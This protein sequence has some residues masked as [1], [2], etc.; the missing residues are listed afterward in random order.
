M[1]DLVS[2][3]YQDFVI[4]NGQFIGKFEEMYEKFPDPWHQSLGA[5]SIPRYLT[6]L[7]IKKFAI[8]SAV[9]F[10][11]GHGFLANLIASNTACKVTGI[12]ISPKAI[13]AARQ[14]F[15]AIRFEAGDVQDIVK[16]KDNDAIIFAEIT[17]YILPMLNKI[18]G[19]MLEHFPG[20]L[21]LH[22][23]VFYKN[24]TQKYG[25]EFFTTPDQFFEFCPFQL[26]EKTV[27][28]PTDPD[29][30]LETHSI[31]RIKSKNSFAL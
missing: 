1:V 6:M 16:Y 14:K 25:R 30:T 21:F 4:K 8:A 23:L 22:N 5:E 11:C 15:P 7:N 13:A 29:A 9:E 31:F 12:D 28:T 18:F 10:G 24:D 3:K 17:W 20:K 19:Q 26:I 2:E 27:V